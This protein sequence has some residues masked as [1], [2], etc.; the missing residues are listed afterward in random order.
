MYFLN[1]KNIDPVLDKYTEKVNSRIGY[2]KIPYNSWRLLKKLASSDLV[3][4]VEIKTSNEEVT[5]YLT[6]NSL[7]YEI[8]VTHGFVNIM[9]ERLIETMYSS[10]SDPTTSNINVDSKSAKKSTFNMNFDFGP[11]SNGVAI[12]PYGLAILAA[13]G[14]WLTYNP[15]NNQ[16]VDVT[17][18]TFNFK[19]M[20]YKVPVAISAIAVGDLIVHQ[21]KPMYVTDVTDN[22]IEVVDILNSEAKKIIP[23]TN[24]FGFNFITKI[25]SIINLGTTTPSPEQPFGNIMPMIMADMVFGGSDGDSAFGNMDMSKLAMISMMTGNANPFGSLF[26][27]NGVAGSAPTSNSK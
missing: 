15:T 4:E 24:M 2:S 13:D 1:S 27:F 21:S 6:N 17:G 18:F 25:T 8:P 5:L 23:V 14:K 9:K 10:T 11:I 16:T 12:S 20:I 7:H 19:G 3:F 26:N 22:N